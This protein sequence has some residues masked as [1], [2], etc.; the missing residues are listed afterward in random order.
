M[1]VVDPDA[2]AVLEGIADGADDAELAV[3]MERVS[4]S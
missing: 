3:L 2:H 4:R 1:Q